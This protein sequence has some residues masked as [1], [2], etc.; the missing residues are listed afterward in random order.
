MRVRGGERKI[1]KVCVWEEKREIIREL[2]SELIQEWLG[3]KEGKREQWGNL[4]WRNREEDRI[5][6]KLNPYNSQGSKT[7][8]N[9]IND[10]N[11]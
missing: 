2:F 6:F 10:Y 3:K 11:P 7:M 1:K 4:A 5:V 9:T 8:I